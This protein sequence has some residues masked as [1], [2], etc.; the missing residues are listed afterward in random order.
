MKKQGTSRETKAK[1][2]EKQVETTKNPN[3]K[4]K[5][6]DTHQKTR[7]DNRRKT[8]ESR[9]KPRENK[10]HEGK[11]RRYGATCSEENQGKHVFICYN[12]RV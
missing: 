4:E 7:K 12:E 10:Q 1:P 2:T 5:P 9:G 8:K 6:M 11:A 3:H